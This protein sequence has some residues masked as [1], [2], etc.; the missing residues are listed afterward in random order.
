MLL[1]TLLFAV[2]VYFVLKVSGNLLRAMR[3]SG[4]LGGGGPRRSTPRRPR[5]ERATRDQWEADV[6]DATWEDL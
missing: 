6:E 2:I 3:Q 4:E 5:N 1:K